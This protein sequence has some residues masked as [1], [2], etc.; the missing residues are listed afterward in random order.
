MDGLGKIYHICRNYRQKT[1]TKKY[2]KFLKK[3]LKFF[4]SHPIGKKSIGGYYEN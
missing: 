3:V 4:K 2:L 1:G